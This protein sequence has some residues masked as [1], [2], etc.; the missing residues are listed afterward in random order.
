MRFMSIALPHVRALVAVS[1][2][3]ATTG[4]QADIARFYELAG[5]EPED[6]TLTGAD[7][8]LAQNDALAA[9]AG[10]GPARDGPLIAVVDSRSRVRAWS[11]LRDAGHWRDVVALRSRASPPGAGGCGNWPAGT[12]GWTSG[13]LW[14]PSPPTGRRRCGSTAAVV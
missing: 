2:D 13:P 1:A 8:I 14:S 10:P 5:R 6:V 9:A 4:F 12:S 11:A 7:T 3:G